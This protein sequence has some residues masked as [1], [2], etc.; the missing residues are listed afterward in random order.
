MAEYAAVPSYMKLDMLRISIKERGLIPRDS[1]F[2]VVQ[3]KCS[4][5]SYKVAGCLP[6]KYACLA[7]G[8]TTSD[9]VPVVDQVLLMASIFLTYMAGVIP[10]EKSYF[11]SQRNVSDDNAV[12]ESSTFSGSALKNG[13][14]VN[15]KCAWDVVK[16][17]LLDSLN[18]IEHIGSLENGVVE[19][20][21]RAKRPLSLH[22]IA[23]GPR[24]RLLWA[25][26]QQLEKEAGSV[27]SFFSG[28]F[29]CVCSVENI[30]ENSETVTMDDWLILFSEIIQKLCQPICMAWLEKECT[31]NRKADKALHTLMFEKLE[32]DTSIYRKLEIQARRIFLR[33]YCAFLDL[34]LSGKFIYGCHFSPIYFF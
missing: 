28:Y 34:G 5:G 8:A 1:Y 6:G 7:D 33:S 30:S 31:E 2:K 24:L 25:S 10:T 15:L 11:S 20:E 19:S 13:D 22:A 4:Y 9:W 23:D 32:G 27:I 17:K 21:Q 14:Q 16:G 3:R 29:S 12:H 26:F 18:A